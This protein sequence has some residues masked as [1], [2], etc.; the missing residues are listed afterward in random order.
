VLIRRGAPADEI[1]K[2]AKERHA[3]LVVVGR[4]GPGLLERFLMGTT[5]ERVVREA[6]CPVLTVHAADVNS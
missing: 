1:L 3:D 4:H 5:A 6:P 2:A